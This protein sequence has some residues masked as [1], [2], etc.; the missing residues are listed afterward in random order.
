MVTL[1]LAACDAPRLPSILQGTNV[2][3]VPNTSKDIGKQSQS[4]PG[5]LPTSTVKQKP[6][7]S[8]FTPFRGAKKKTIS[9]PLPDWKKTV[10][11]YY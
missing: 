4:R 9:S 6:L 5:S 3:V 8:F 11:Q 7:E 2:S 1:N 10:T